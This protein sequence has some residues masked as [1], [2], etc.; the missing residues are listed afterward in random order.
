MKKYQLFLALALLL[1]FA[2]NVQAYTMLMGEGGSNTVAGYTIVDNSGLANTNAYDVD[3]YGYLGSDELL[4]YTGYYL[5]TVLDVNT[6]P[7]ALSALINYYVGF[8]YEFTELKVDIEVG[9]TTSGPLHVD[10]SNLNYGTWNFTV[11][12]YELGFYAVKGGNDFAL[13]FVDPAVS[14]GFWNTS[15]LVNGGSN[16][17]EISHFSAAAPVPEPATML[18]LGT[19]LIGLAGVSRKK[20]KK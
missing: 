16:P 6:S 13:Y 5:G 11:E 10:I 4:G 18:L 9:D 14:S 3:Y 12:G 15:H 17:P 19:G 1:G 8:D 7:D 2:L 20:F